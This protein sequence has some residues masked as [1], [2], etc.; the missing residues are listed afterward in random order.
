MYNY[1]VLW[2][3]LDHS[4]AI[5]KSKQSDYSN[6]HH[7]YS[8]PEIPRDK[9][10]LATFSILQEKNLHRKILF[11]W[12]THSFHLFHRHPA[13]IC[14]LS[15]HYYCDAIKYL[16]ACKSFFITCNYFPVKKW[17]KGWLRDFQR[18]HLF[19]PKNLNCISG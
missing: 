11:C 1:C 15:L 9:K 17:Q 12:T 2:F 3:L 13:F 19:D 14:H 8:L 6:T 10:L 7:N 16:S 18:M 5:N 4:T